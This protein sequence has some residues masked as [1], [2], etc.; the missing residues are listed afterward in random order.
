[1]LNRAPGPQV[2]DLYVPL[3]GLLEEG[4]ERVWTFRRR[5]EAKVPRLDANRGGIPGWPRLIPG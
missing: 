4:G 1:M 5:S 2:Y 3:L